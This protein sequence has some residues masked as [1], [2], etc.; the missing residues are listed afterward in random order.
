MYSYAKGS[1]IFVIATTS[2]GCLGNYGCPRY[3][4]SRIRLDICLNKKRT[5]EKTI[6]VFIYDKLKKTREDVSWPNIRS[7]Q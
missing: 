3:S 6:L 4:Y 5:T 2:Y 1:E 7:I